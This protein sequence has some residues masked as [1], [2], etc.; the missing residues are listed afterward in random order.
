MLSGINW[1]YGTLQANE[2]EH[3]TLTSQSSVLHVCTYVWKREGNTETRCRLRR[4]DFVG[5]V[6]FSPENLSLLCGQLV[7]YIGS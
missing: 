7:I 4:N 1:D 2:D 5:A 6:L 3:F